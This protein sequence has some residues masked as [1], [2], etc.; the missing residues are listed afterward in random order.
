VNAGNIM[1]VVEAS[2]SILA[3]AR[4]DG[5]FGPSS[6]TW[7]VIGHPMAFVGGLRSLIIGALHPLVAAGTVVCT[8]PIP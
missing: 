7:R 3:A 8:E 5:L 1:S 6:V 4:D 2:T